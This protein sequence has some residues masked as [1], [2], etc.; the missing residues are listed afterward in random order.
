MNRRIRD[1]YV[2]W[3][4]PKGWL[5]QEVHWRG[6]NPVS[7]LLDYQL[8]VLIFIIIIHYC[9]NIFLSVCWGGTGWKVLWQN[10]VRALALCVLPMMYLTAKGRER[11]GTQYLGLSTLCHLFCFNRLINT[12]PFCVIW[13]F[14]FELFAFSGIVHSIRPS[15][16]SL[17]TT[18]YS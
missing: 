10:L 4:A 11:W 16:L 9:C 2:R 5:C 12:I 13:Y 3:C 17:L 6:Y 8:A 1:P 7:R 15:S 18:E 14:C